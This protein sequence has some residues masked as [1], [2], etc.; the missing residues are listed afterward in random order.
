MTRALLFFGECAKNDRPHLA[1]NQQRCRRGT[2]VRARL[3]S[4]IA[5]AA[6]K[7]PARTRSLPMSLD[8]A[9]PAAVWTHLGSD[10]SKN[11]RGLGG[12]GPRCPERGPR[13]APYSGTRGIEFARTFFGRLDQVPVVRPQGCRGTHIAVIAMEI[14]AVGNRG[15][16]QLALAWDD[17]LVTP[18]RLL[19]RPENVGA[20]SSVLGFW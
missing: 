16:R 17:S 6:S 7:A 5:S 19:G 12:G 14:I 18:L 11:G 3:P 4:S 13:V 2:W 10:R 20:R 15:N 8:A 1:E 9:Q